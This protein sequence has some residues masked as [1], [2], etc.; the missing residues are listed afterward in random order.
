MTTLH[1]RLVVF[2]V[3]LLGLFTSCS[4]EDDTTSPNPKNTTIETVLTDIGFQGYAIVTKNGKDLVRQGF[5][6]A[7][8]NTELP[9]GDNLG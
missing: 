7:N 6:W 4:K 2:M 9:Q 8:Q 3:S 1:K 5:G